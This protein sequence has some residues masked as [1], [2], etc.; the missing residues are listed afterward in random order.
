MD[1]YLY[2]APN[3]GEIATIEGAELAAS[4]DRHK[5]A[6]RVTETIVCLDPRAEIGKRP[7]LKGVV[8]A[9]ERGWA[10]PSHLRFAGAV[11]KRG[12]RAWFYWPAEEAVESLDDER[13]ASFWRHWAVITAHRIKSAISRR[14]FGP[15]P[16]PDP[17]VALAK[18][19]VDQLREQTHEP[20]NDQLAHI[21]CPSCWRRRS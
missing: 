21:R 8:I 9:L 17:T 4:E 20:Q 5:V 6:L 10:G 12:L 3:L 7:N 11:R 16:P 15:P 2:V 1:Q 18:R 13:M 19:T 14:I